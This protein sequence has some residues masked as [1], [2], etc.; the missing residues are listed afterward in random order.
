MKTY[1]GVTAILFGLLTAAHI[2]R[3][4]V[5]PNLV[6]DPWFIITTVISTLLCIWGA[7]LLVST[8]TQAS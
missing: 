3:M 1:L 8:R 6:S 4:F 7:R 2:W 5:E